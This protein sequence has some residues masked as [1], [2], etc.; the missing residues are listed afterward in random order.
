MTLYDSS[1]LIDYLAND[2]E[3][4]AYAEE[5]A[6]EQAKTIHLVCYEVYLGELHTAGDPDFEAVGDALSWVTVVNYQSRRTSRN[7][8]ELMARLHENGSPLGAVDG[9]IAA[10]AWELNETLVTRDADFDTPVVR[11]E[12]DVDIV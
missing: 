2:P 12:I 8:A 9:F 6:R 10:A 1:F 11:S 7:A 4:V 5:H 3:S